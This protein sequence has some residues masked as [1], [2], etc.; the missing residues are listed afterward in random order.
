MCTSKISE[1]KG[2]GFKRERSVTLGMERKQQPKGDAHAKWKEE[3]HPEPNCVVWFG[4]RRKALGLRFRAPGL[5]RPGQAGLDVGRQALQRPHKFGPAAFI[6]NQNGGRIRA[7]RSLFQAAAERRRYLTHRTIDMRLAGRRDEDRGCF[8][9]QPGRSAGHR[10][11]RVNSRRAEDAVL[12]KA[13]QRQFP[14][15]PGSPG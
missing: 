7:G 3:F 6:G 12:V 1:G 5:Y 2:D 14:R 15:S 11:T 9:G 4:W 10:V 13:C 8:G